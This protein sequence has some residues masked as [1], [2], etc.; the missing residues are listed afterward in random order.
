[1]FYQD[2]YKGDIQMASE[3]EF[4]KSI[5]SIPLSAFAISYTPFFRKPFQ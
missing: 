3:L 1:V 4:F 5:P 2:F